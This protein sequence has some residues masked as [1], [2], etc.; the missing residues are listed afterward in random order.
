MYL[1]RSYNNPHI[2]VYDIDYL[3]NSVPQTSENVIFG[4]C[5]HPSSPNLVSLLFAP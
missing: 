5:T 3:M 1:P 2:I 4:K